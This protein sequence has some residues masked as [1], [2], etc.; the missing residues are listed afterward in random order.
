[1]D[2]SIALS[3]TCRATLLLIARAAW[4]GRPRTSA[5]AVRGYTVSPLPSPLGSPSKL[6]RTRAGHGTALTCSCVNGR[7]RAWNNGKRQR[8]LFA[9]ELAF[10]RAVL[11]CVRLPMQALTLLCLPTLAVTSPL[12][13]DS[14][15]PILRKGTC[16][17]LLIMGVTTVFNACWK[18]STGRVN[19]I[20]CPVRRVSTCPVPRVNVAFDNREV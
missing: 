3:L 20:A 7:T 10:R 11:D 12:V 19:A 9:F 15:S 6:G 2:A 13:P 16:L 5:G 8:D 18:I 1:M 4:L 17:T 14:H